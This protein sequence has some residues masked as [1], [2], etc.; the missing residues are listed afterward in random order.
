MPTLDE[1]M[2]GA[3]TNYTERGE[4]RAVVTL[5]TNQNGGIASY[6]TGVLYYLPPV[7]DPGPLQ[8][9]E[10]LS[11]RNT[12]PLPYLFSNRPPGD[13]P[14]GATFADQLGLSLTT[15]GPA[16]FTL[17]TW[18]NHEFNVTFE[19]RGDV[20]VGTGEAIAGAPEGSE[21]VYVISFNEL[22]KLI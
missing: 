18:G 22:P 16:K 15:D 9:A 6:A 11:T 5:V 7:G 20:L 4:G 17:L 8:I 19:S 1:A 13:Q 2:S 3:R 12:E 10:R 21:A 14:F